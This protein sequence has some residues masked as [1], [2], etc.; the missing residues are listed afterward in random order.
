MKVKGNGQGNPK[1]GRKSVADD[2]PE[3]SDPLSLAS[4]SLDHLKW[5]EVRGYSERTVQTRRLHLSLF[6]IGVW[7]VVLNPRQRSR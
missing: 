3:T 6:C 5:L 1:R 7:I 2:W 4:L